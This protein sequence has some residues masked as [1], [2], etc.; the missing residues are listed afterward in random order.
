MHNLH[1][2]ENL[3]LY[4]AHNGAIGDLGDLSEKYLSDIHFASEM[5]TEVVV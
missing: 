1:A 3:S 5:N 4:L 2:S